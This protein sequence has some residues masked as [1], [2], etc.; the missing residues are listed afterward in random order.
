M[1]EVLIIADLLFWP[2]LILII[3]FKNYGNENIIHLCQNF[4]MINQFLVIISILCS[5][6]LLNFI[7]MNGVILIIIFYCYFFK[8]KNI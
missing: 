6:K 3:T 8:F 2:I 7:E 4:I 1:I 5:K